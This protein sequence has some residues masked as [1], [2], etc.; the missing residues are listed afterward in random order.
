MKQADDTMKKVSGQAL[1]TRNFL[2]V[3][4]A[5]LC[6]CMAGYAIMPVLPLYLMD[7]LHCQKTV[8]GIAMAV[9]PL[10]ALLFRPF[11][12]SLPTGST[13]SSFSY[14]PRWHAWPAFRSALRPRACCSSCSSA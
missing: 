12:G 11:P 3:C 14:S 4:M 5:N 7:E 6:T 9:F 2:L 8:M 10:V 1:F 13:E